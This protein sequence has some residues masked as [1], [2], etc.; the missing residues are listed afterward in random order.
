[1]RT[2]KAAAVALAGLVIAFPGLALA[3]DV[4]RF[5]HVYEEST[6]YHAAA[7]KASELLEERTD[8]RY[9]MDVFPASQLGTDATHNEALSLGTIDGIYTGIAFLGQSYPPIAISDFPFTIRSYDHWK[10]Y[11]D[12]ELFDELAEAYKEVS[13][14]TIAG[15]TYYGARHVTANKPIMTPDD[16]VGLKIRTPPAPAFQLFPQATGA[17]PTPLSFAE[18]Y[19]AL[20]QGVVDAQENPLPAIQVRRFHE[21]QS[22]ISLTGH[23]WNSLAIVVSPFTLEKLGDEDAQILLDALAEAS[24]TT[25]DEVAADELEL[26]DWFRGQGATVNEVDR[27]PFVDAVAPYL[28]SD[29]MPWEASVYERLQALD[30]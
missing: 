25:S 22:D 29:A 30:G 15:I 14:N 7:L 17:N 27:Q 11:A 12:S 13:G 26:V 6:P 21:V 23:I 1:M 2:L 19:L 5:A 8:G 3:Q 28:T 16:M 20:Q 10:S 4:L 9:R 24:S 18:V